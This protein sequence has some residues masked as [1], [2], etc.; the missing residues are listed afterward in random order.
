MLF[1]TMFHR[2]NGFLYLRRV[3]PLKRRPALGGRTEIRISLK[4]R[5]CRLVLLSRRYARAEDQDS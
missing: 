1:A 4:T 3:V 5:S 2:Q